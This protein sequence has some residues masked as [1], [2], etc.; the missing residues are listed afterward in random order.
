MVAQARCRKRAADL[1]RHGIRRKTARH[2]GVRFET[3]ALEGFNSV[4]TEMDPEYVKDIQ[5]RL[6]VASVDA[7]FDVDVP[8]LASC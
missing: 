4:L 2:V 5:N 1:R 7:L 6:N 3:A 8:L